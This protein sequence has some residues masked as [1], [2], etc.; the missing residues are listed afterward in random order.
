MR[1]AISA[2]EKLARIL[3]VDASPLDMVAIARWAG[4]EIEAEKAQ[5]IAVFD[6]GG[7]KFAGGVSMPEPPKAAPGADA[8]PAADPVAKEDANADLSLTGLDG[9]IYAHW[10]GLEKL[11]DWSLAD[12]VDIL[13][14]AH[15]GWKIGEIATN[16]NVDGSQVIKRFDAMIGRPK[17][18]SKESKFLRADVFR[19]LKGVLEARGGR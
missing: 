10:Q 9:E 7:L 5:W 17:P 13:E 16:L 11:P 19:V 4:A 2:L 14:K 1:I 8:E 6:V 3:P 12:D 15:L 18:T